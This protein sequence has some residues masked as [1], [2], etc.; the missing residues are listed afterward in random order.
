MAAC[1]GA[2]PVDAYEAALDSGQAIAG[3]KAPGHGLILWE[4]EYPPAVDPFAAERAT[5]PAVPPEPPF[6][7]SR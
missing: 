4:V 5:I 1:A 7:S 3:V 6:V 2:L